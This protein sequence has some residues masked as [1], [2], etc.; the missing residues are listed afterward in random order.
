MLNEKITRGFLEK[1]DA[2]LETLMGAT[3]PSERSEMDQVTNLIQIQQMLRGELQIINQLEFHRRQQGDI[4]PP[5]APWDEMPAH[6]GN[7]QAVQMP[8]VNLQ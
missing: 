2:Q 8:P 3:D 4:L 5:P 6:V 7:I 1:I